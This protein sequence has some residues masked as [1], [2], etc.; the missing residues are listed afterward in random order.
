MKETFRQALLRRA[1]DLAGGVS[2]LS[3]HLAISVDDL[4]AM[5]HGQ[6]EIPTAVFYKA[7]DYIHENEPLSPAPPASPAAA[8]DADPDVKT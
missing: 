5:L 1:R 2:P 4:E 6:M 8:S 3:R 7:A